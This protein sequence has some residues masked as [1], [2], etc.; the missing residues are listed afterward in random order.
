[1]TIAAFI[2]FAQPRDAVQYGRRGND[3]NPAVD[4][5]GDLPDGGKKGTSEDLSSPRVHAVNF[6][7][8]TGLD[9]VGEHSVSDLFR[10]PGGPD[11]GHGFRMKQLVRYQGIHWYPIFRPL[12]WRIPDEPT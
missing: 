11:D 12:K 8:E 9:Q 1:M 4:L 10:L 5:A 7:G 6:S 2:P 3:E